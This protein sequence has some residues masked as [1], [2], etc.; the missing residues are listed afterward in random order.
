[1]VTSIAERDSINNP[2]EGSLAYV[3]NTGGG[4]GAAEWTIYIYLTGIGWSELTNQDA[5]LVDAGSAQ[6]EITNTTGSSTIPLKIVSTQSR[7]FA[8]SVDVTIAF[9]A[10]T[11][12]KVGDANDDDRFMTVDENDLSVIGTYLS[13]PAFCYDTTTENTVTVTIE[14]ANNPTV[15]EAKVLMSYV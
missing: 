6:I 9:N 12:V 2:A 14:N 11:T 13:T 3:K 1:M 7:P 15:G 10:E 5:A 8:V 4:Q